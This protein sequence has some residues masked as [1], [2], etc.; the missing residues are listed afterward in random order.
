[1]EEQ[2]LYYKLSNHIAL[3]DEEKESMYQVFSYRS[4][5][6]SRERLWSCIKY[7]IYNNYGI[8]E[9]VVFINGKCRYIAGQSYPDEI[10][11]VR[12]LIIGK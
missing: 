2:T 9:R 3:T 8:Y 12:N 11:L 4:H 6:K 5:K 1:M 10:R 7:G